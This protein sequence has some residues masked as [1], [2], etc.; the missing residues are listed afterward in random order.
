MLKKILLY[1][2]A[3]IVAILVGATLR[4][5]S[6]AVERRIDINAPPEKI[7][8]NL[9]DFKQWAEWSP[10]EK[11]DPKM[12]KTLGGPPSGVGA[13]YAWTGNSDVGAGKM[14]VT[15]TT[16]SSQVVVRIDFLKPMESLGNNATFTLAPYGASTAVVWR[17]E[18]P[19]PYVSKVMNMFVSMDRMIGGDF[20]KG[21]SQ[22]K[23]LSEK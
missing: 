9:I 11:L 1:A 14:E 15:G 5:D 17:M 19:S 16:P 23:T 4:P 10:W 21:L 22:L 20:E 2:L 18:G 12:T 7:Y 6:F 13:T 3:L 8:A